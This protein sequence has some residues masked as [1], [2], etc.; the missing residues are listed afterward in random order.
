MQLRGGTLKPGPPRVPFPLVD[1]LRETIRVPPPG[2][3][4]GAVDGGSLSV[5]GVLV[6][7]PLKPSPPTPHKDENHRSGRGAKMRRRCRF[8]CSRENRERGDS[9]GEGR[10]SEAQS[11]IPT[12]TQGTAWPVPAAERGALDSACAFRA[13]TS[14]ARHPACA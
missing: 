14:R 10:E 7:L 9:S 13:W 1:D 12:A 5:G 11:P 4:T 8:P 2:S 3:L 6:E